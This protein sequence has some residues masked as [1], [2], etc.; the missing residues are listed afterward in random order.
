MVFLHIFLFM[1]LLIIANQNKIK[2]I[3][4]LDKYKLVNFLKI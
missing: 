1:I 4:P 2:L 3:I